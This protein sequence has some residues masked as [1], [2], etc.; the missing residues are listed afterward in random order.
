MSTTTHLPAFALLGIALWSLSA[1]ERDAPTASTA[2]HISFL[3]DTVEW[4]YG[5]C[6]DP[7]SGPC[8]HVRLVWLS[9]TGEPAEVVRRINDTLHAYQH[10]DLPYEA[11]A[12]WPRTAEE[13]ARAFIRAFQRYGSADQHWEYE[14]IS[15]LDYE[16]EKVWSVRIQSHSYT[17]GAHPNSYVRWLAFAKSDGHRLGWSELLRDEAAFR[18]LAGKLLRQAR[19]RHS[20]ADSQAA[21]LMQDDAF[22]LPQNFYV[23]PEGLYLY[24]N[25][26]EGGPYALG[27]TELMIDRQALEGIVRHELLW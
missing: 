16:T 26:Y 3:R 19:M 7:A 25:P 17:G 20:G 24:Y 1:C 14:Q 27:P 12:P 21:G 9:A 18:A 6:D 13:E 5:R 23:R 8:A 2:I 10:L 22:A 11:E 4:S 15:S